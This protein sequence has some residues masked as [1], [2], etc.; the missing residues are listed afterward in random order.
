MYRFGPFEIETETAELRKH[1]LR[2]RIQEQP[3]RILL[4]LLERPGQIVTRNEI[5]TELWPEGTYVDFDR[6]MNSA[7]T[8]LRQILADSAESPRYIE[9][10]A[11][12]GYRFIAPVQILEP[13]GA[14][15][16]PAV[17][18]GRSAGRL[19]VSRWALGAA[20]VAVVAAVPYILRPSGDA[21]HE[22]Y[23]VVPLTTLPGSEVDP[24]F[25][26]DGR[27]VVFAWDA[28]NDGPLNLYVKRIGDENPRRLTT[29]D[30]VDRSPAWSPDG[31][32][33]AFLRRSPSKISVMVV[34]AAG[35]R[36]QVVTETAPWTGADFFIGFVTFLCW[37]ADNKWLIFPDYDETVGRV[38]LSAIA[39][40]TGER[41]RLTRPSKEW[42]GDFSPVLSPDSRT[43][44][45]VRLASLLPTDFWTI[46]LNKDLSPAAE[47]RRVLLLQAAAAQAVW[48]SNS[49][50]LLVPL[51]T[52]T[53]GYRLHHFAVSDPR[54]PR[55]LA[56]LSNLGGC[57]AISHSA[58]RLVS[59][60][61]EMD[62]N[63]WRIDLSRN[64]GRFGERTPLAGPARVLITSS[65]WDGMPQYSPDGKNIVFNS[66]R[67]GNP[68]LWMTD[69]DGHH[70]RKL[71]E[72]NA[73]LTGCPS[74]SPDGRQIAFASH[75]KTQGDV[76]VL[77]AITGAVRQLTDDN[78]DDAFPAWSRDGRWVYFESR[79]T[80]VDEIWKVPAA[81]GQALQVTRKGGCYAAESWDSKYLYFS[82][83]PASDL[84]RMPA[85]GGPEE[86][87][88]TGMANETTWTVSRE[89]IWFIGPVAGRTGNVL[90]VLDLSNGNIRQ[91]FQIARPLTLGVAVSPDER[92][93]LWS[94]MD[95]ITS[96]LMLVEQF[97]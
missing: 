38:G 59:C 85:S 89:R 96:D 1:G 27:E 23:A 36:G 94:Q 44:A 16:T 92:S 87:I 22:P 31:R 82:K 88:L 43:L 91:I 70:P 19:K 93:V 8:R 46:A 26:P 57:L 20:A 83:C 21:F 37:S 79:R 81:G 42:L 4:M 15:H 24:S 33:I 76:Y 90:K 55:L 40:G 7:I 74:W 18:P 3:F 63:V 68:E 64:G 62:E 47:P 72:L 2:I 30:Y 97:P 75:V 53:G 67:S 71:T 39:P 52:P 9:T 29:S 56:S 54:H 66:D 11:K 12:R 41:R 61:T 50:E 10:V 69:A 14:Q 51:R 77:D 34:P 58:R 78:E 86:R 35:G 25:S 49:R 80:G 45:F 95:R 73:R 60:R 65:A 6:G 17:E 48:T 84:W 28:G 5:A 13:A 32:S